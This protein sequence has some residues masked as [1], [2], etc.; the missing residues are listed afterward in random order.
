[1]ER[2]QIIGIILIMATFML[3]TI[4]SSPSKE[5]L[6][7]SRKLQ[8]SIALAKQTAEKSISVNSELS[9]KTVNVNK[10]NDSV[11]SQLNNLKFGAFSN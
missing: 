10:E 9:E 6:E 7:K 2:N 11:S 4:T 8:D 5:E 3:W 1:M